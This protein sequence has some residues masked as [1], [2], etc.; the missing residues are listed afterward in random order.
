MLTLK[1]THFVGYGHGTI[2]AARSIH[3]DTVALDRREPGPPY[4][5]RKPLD[6]SDILCPVRDPVPG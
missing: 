6:Q 1:G 4:G 5:P 3:A 2:W